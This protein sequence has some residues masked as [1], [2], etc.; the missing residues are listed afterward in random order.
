MTYI[1]KFSKNL[2]P[3]DIVVIGF[4]LFLT[5]LNLI[6]LSKI[7]SWPILV[8][9]DILL[10]FFVLW[11][12]NKNNTSDSKIWEIIHFYYV[13]PLIFLTFKQVYVLIRALHTVD[14][15]DL[16]IAADRFLFGG[17]PTVFLFQFCPL[18]S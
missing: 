3:T 14:Y 12:A 6:F 13:V 1:Q 16:L 8:G 2:N 17:D 5:G 10:I 15:D 11:I 18:F 7:E 9:L 4:Y